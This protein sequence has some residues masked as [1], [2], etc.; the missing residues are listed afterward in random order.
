[1]FV[2]Q[3]NFQKFKEQNHAHLLELYKKNNHLNREKKCSRVLELY[4]CKRHIKQ[5]MNMEIVY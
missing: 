5:L 1:M 2:L 3:K 4:H